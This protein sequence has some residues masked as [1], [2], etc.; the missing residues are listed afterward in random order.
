MCADNYFS[1]QGVCKECTDAHMLTT[2]MIMY[3]CIAVVILGVILAALYYKYLQGESIDD[4]MVDISR[5][6]SRA[7]SRAS[8]GKGSIAEDRL[9][10]TELSKDSLGAA[11]NED[12]NDPTRLEMLALWLHERFPRLMVKFKIIVV[13][14]QVVSSVPSSLDVTMPKIFTD[15]VDSFNFLNLSLAAAFPVSCSSRYT[16]IDQ[17]VLTTLAPL[18][19]ILLLV[20]TFFIEYAYHRRAIQKKRDRK[21]GEKASKFNEVKDRYWNYVF[22]LTYIIMPSVTTTIFATFICTS[23]DPDDESAEGDD[24]Y[25]VADMSISCHSDYY[26]GGLMYACL[27][28]VV[29]PGLFCCFLKKLKSSI[30]LIKVVLVWL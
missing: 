26:R 27:M 28:I 4:R 15:F 24:L 14:L 16:F 10:I 2:S 12:E 19:I 9:S 21:R 3:I 11:N 29:Y 5:R 6:A 13:T 18:A 17:L 22:Y 7:G 8:I 1:D 30:Y 20:I 25:L 23:I